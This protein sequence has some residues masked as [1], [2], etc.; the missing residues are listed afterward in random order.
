MS[1]APSW[2]IVRSWSIVSRFRHGGGL[3]PHQGFHAVLQR[4]LHGRIGPDVDP[5]VGRAPLIGDEPINRRL[6]ND[7]SVLA[8][9]RAEQDLMPRRCI[10]ARCNRGRE[11]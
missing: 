6:F 11:M 4:M 2:S 10:A 5:A 3:R 1:V 9:E 8:L 7:R